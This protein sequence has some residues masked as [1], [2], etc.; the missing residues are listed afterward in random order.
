LIG[1]C[2]GL[3]DPEIGRRIDAWDAR[4]T[5]RPAW[6]AAV[7]IAHI[8]KDKGDSVLSVPAEA[9]LEDAANLLSAHKVGAVV[10][11]SG[12]GRLAGVLSERDIVREIAKRGPSALADTVSSAMTR[13]VITAR[14]D[15]SIDDGLERMTDRRIRHLP[16]VDGER[17]VGIISIGDLV[18]R[19]IEAVQFEAV[20]LRS[21][22]AAG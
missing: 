7:L 14:P 3:S 9:S 10:V 13:N 2:R 8:L 12:A 20:A 22:I 6:E 18:K 5:R 21:Y 4:R 11:L 15:E 17:L 1:V 19:K 16:I